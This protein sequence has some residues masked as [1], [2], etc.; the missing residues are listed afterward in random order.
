ME[1]GTG[2]RNGFLNEGPCV[3]HYGKDKDNVVTNDASKTG[4]GIILWQK[5]VKGDIKPTAYGSRYLNDTE[6]NYSIG[7]LAL[8]A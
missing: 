5:Q 2:T 8:L 4:L 7:E 3:A 1:M 6:K